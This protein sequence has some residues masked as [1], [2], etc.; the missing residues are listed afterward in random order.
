[1]PG[2]ICCA[3]SHALARR[4]EPP[5]FRLCCPFCQLTVLSMLMVGALRQ[6]GALVANQFVSPM[7][8]SKSIAKPSWSSNVCGT[9][10]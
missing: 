2:T 5:M 1:M 10:L 8:P 7:L 6:L 3:F 4:Y 9:L